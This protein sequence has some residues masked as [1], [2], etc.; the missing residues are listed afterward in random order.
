M[1]H[2]ILIVE[3]EEEIVR[4]IHNRINPERY[5]VIIAEEGKEALA[6]IARETFDVAVI[7]IMIPFIDGFEVCTQLR[8]KNKETLILII[9][10]LG[11]EEN[12]LKGY[13]LGADDF[14]PKPFSPRELMAKID[15]LIKR[16]YEMINHNVTV[17]RSITHD[18][19]GK[20]IEIEGEVLALTPSEYLIFAMLL[21]N[22]KNILSRDQL[23]QE[24]YDNDMGE[25]D[26]R[27]IDTH[28]YNL[29]KKIVSITSQP[30]IHTERSLG[31]TIHAL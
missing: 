9:S 11:N 16:R 13:D 19:A 31:Y 6:S 8:R 23:A 24:I 26:A 1:K 28:I 21:A 17:L 7:D 18:K 12:K 2:T 14:I 30:I 22:P 20:K 10:A 4:L 5:D 27:G 29:R 15:A 25:I 3:D